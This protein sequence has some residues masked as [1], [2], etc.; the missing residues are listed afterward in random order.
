MSLLYT[1][2]ELM[3][4]M[5]RRT[6]GTAIKDPFS[7]H[8][9]TNNATCAMGTRGRQRVNS[10]FKAVEY[11]CLTTHAHFKALI[12]GVATYFTGT[13]PVTPHRI[14]FIIHK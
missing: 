5:L 9:M 10:T 11:V 6:M 14:L 2:F 12:V 1:V 13:F 4:A 7:F 8:S 3:D